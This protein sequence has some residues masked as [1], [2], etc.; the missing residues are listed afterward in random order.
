MIYIRDSIALRFKPFRRMYEN[1]SKI[2]LN[3]T[4]SKGFKRMKLTLVC[5]CVS[6]KS[7][8]QLSRYKVVLRLLSINSFLFNGKL[9]NLEKFKSSK[10]L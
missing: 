10:W 6:L 7:L 1:G 3:L 5:A 9:G 8:W 2:A 4:C